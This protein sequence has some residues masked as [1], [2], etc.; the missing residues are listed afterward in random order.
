MAIDTPAPADLPAVTDAPTA[1]ALPMDAATIRALGY[2]I[3]DMIARELEDPARRPVYPP[4]QR[5]DDIEAVFGGPVPRSGRSPD[6]LLTLL[7]ERLLPIA[8][9][10]G[11]P[12]LMGYVLS[13]P[14]PLAGL[15]EAL[16]STLRMVPGHWRWHPAN[17][18][19]EVTV[20]RWLGE[21]VGFGDDAVGYM[22]TGGSWA[23]LMG[24]AV[25]RV[26]R[27][28]WD[29]RA[30][31]LAGRPQLTAYVSEEGHS[32]LDK[33]MELMGMGHDQLRKVPVGGDFRIRLDAL[34]AA[35][36]ADV[37]AGHR[38][39][40][41]VGNAGTV[42]TGAVDPLAELA[43]LAGR[44]GL[45]FHV[46]GAYGALATLDPA[47]RGLFAGIEAADSLALDPHKWLNVPFDA[48]CLLTRRW[49]DLADAFSLV[50]PYIRAATDAEHNHMHYGFELSRTD[51][52][53][54]VWLSLQQHGVDAYAAMIAGHIAL[55]S[56]LADVL[57]G[58]PDFEVMSEPVLSIC[59]FRY[60]PSDLSAGP[61]PVE[62]YLDALNQAVELGLM[63]DG[64]AMV[65]G[66]ELRGRR[67][68]RAC[69]V[70]HRATRDHVDA[71]IE[72]LREIGRA[73][74]ARMRAEVAALPS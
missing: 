34:E 73:T 49:A 11:H 45:W 36:E 33:A 57:R 37:A 5:R 16:T 39:F 10:F 43:A 17:S 69:I 9:N 41:V 4:P 21:I 27:A 31:G 18:W 61:E 12:R 6:E 40:C 42:N 26:R 63:D 64:R 67:V 53:L 68:L 23:N 2:R 7:E 13:N 60:V 56:H 14:L 3:V 1:P 54:K 8:A 72:L 59:C 44:H 65:S 55:A 22:A 24:L 74:D 58:A 19:I 35:I 15:I 70:N 47:K 51:R 46:D 66:T 29:V 50:P 32:C 71:T 28:G 48:G 25:A 52:A 30:E 20:A 62:R 38:P